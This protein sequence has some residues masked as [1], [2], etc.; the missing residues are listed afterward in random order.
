MA[1]GWN[2]KVIGLSLPLVFPIDFFRDA[3]LAIHQ[4]DAIAVYDDGLVQPTHAFC[5]YEIELDN[6]SA[7]TYTT[8]ETY[9]KWTTFDGEEQSERMTT[10]DTSVIFHPGYHH[11]IYE[12]PQVP[13]Q[14]HYNEQTVIRRVTGTIK[15][16]VHAPEPDRVTHAM[17]VMIYGGSKD[18]NSYTMDDLW[19][20]SRRG[21]RVFSVTPTTW[22]DDATGRYVEFEIAADTAAAGVELFST[23]MPTS[24]DRRSVNTED[25]GITGVILQYDRN[26]SVPNFNYTPDDERVMP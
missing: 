11:H 1:P 20:E 4:A 8:T 2:P 26:A 10:R 6:N 25:L 19:S 24:G 12:S 22:R 5:G 13:G 18:S 23:A 3:Y 9:R 14:E 21:Y 7:Q 17:I 15:V 16:R